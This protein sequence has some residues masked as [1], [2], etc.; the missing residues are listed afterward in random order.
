MDAIDQMIDYYNK[1]TEDF[2]HETAGM[3]LR[4]LEKVKDVSIYDMADLCYTSTSTISRLVQKMGFHNYRDFK[5][6]ITYA[7]ENY[8][9]LNRNMRD[10]EI[11][12]DQDIMPLYFN[13]LIN[14]I[15]SLQNDL[16]YEKISRIS[17]ILF[18]AKE[19]FLL[20]Q[21]NILNNIQ[22]MMILSGK[23]THMC[24]V[25]GTQEQLKS[26][27]LKPDT[28]SAVLFVA[29]PD[30]REMLPMRSLLK[31]AQ[32]KEIYTITICSGNENVYSDY[33]DCQI[34]FQGTKTSMDIY[35]FTIINNLIRADFSNRYL[36][37]VLEKYI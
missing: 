1:T 24:S 35:L 37:N 21:T 23:Q 28:D 27:E 33:S 20:D 14:N 16:T 4:N 12:D 18:S 10:M 17:D 29:I 31:Q 6:K 9:F 36:N 3:L 25:A 19:V 5:S 34:A 13:F 11:V 15:R 32:N 30:L 2:Y 26:I 22:K 8:R 7:L